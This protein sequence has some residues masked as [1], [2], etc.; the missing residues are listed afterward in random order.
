M[1]SKKDLNAIE[2][3]GVSMKHGHAAQHYCQVSGLSGD[4]VSKGSVHAVSATQQD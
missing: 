3:M 1:V 4:H 2:C